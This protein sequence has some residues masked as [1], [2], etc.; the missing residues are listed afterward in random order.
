[1]YEQY[2]RLPSSVHIV[3]QESFIISRL[4]ELE[5]KEPAFANDL[6]RLAARQRVLADVP[7]TSYK[8]GA[9]ILTKSNQVYVGA[10][11]ENWTLKTSIHAEEAAVKAAKDA[12]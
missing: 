5:A 4:R 6:A 1:M 3:E 2:I 11:S 9:A 8:V 7:V 10:N 12:A